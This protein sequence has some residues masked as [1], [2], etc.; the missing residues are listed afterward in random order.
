MI[1][2]DNYIIQDFYKERLIVSLFVQDT[3]LSIVL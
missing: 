1:S 3:I 2:L